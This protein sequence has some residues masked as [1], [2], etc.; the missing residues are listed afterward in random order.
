MR[1][2]AAEGEAAEGE[3]AEGEAAV[4]Q[5]EATVLVH[6]AACLHIQAW[7]ARAHKNLTNEAQRFKHAWR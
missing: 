6:R 2:A 3:A 7:G 1:E 5:P 4:M